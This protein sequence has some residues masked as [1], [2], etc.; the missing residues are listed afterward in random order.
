M[1]G[2]TKIKVVQ[3]WDDGVINDIR[4]TDLCRKYGAKATFNLNPGLMGDS[5]RPSRWL[6]VER[7]TWSFHGYQGGK[8]A[9]KDIPEVYHGFELASHCL[10]HENADRMPADE[11]IKTAVDARKILEDIVQKPC[12]GFAWP[13]GRHTPETRAALREAG[14]SY[15]RTTANMPDITKCEDTMALPSNCHFTSN[16]FF[17]L[18]ENA[19]AEGV[20]VFYFWGHSYE[21][22]EYDK[23]WEQYELKLDYISNDPD[24]EWANVAEIAPLC[25]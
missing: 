1:S 21:M 7:N 4:L 24:A 6:G 15:G 23:L 3:C 10:N 13:C 22:Y 19:K 8:L 5:R 20:K 18:Y 9:L 16:C 2:K 17:D 14:F 11:W 25:Q 12:T